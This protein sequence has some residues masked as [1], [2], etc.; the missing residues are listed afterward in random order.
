MAIP[1]VIEGG[2]GQVKVFTRQETLAA[3]EQAPEEPPLGDW[4]PAAEQSSGLSVAQDVLTGEPL[5]AL[6]IG[7]APTDDGTRVPAYLRR[8][9]W[10]ECPPP[11]YHVAAMRSWRDRHGAECVGI[12]PETIDIRVARKPETR[13]EALALAREHSVSC[14]DVIDQGVKSSSARAADLMAH[15]RWFFWWD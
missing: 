11:E 9:G 12:N 6:Y 2:G 8:G 14:N 5:A 3:L 1:T 10:N 15:G 7:V 13:A 4:R